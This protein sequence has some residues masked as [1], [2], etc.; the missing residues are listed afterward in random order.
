MTKHE[1]NQPVNPMDTHPKINDSD[2][3]LLQDE[4]NKSIASVAGPQSTG[5]HDLNGDGIPDA[6]L[7]WWNDKKVLFI[8]DDGTLPW[9][10]KEE[11]RDWNQ[12]F[13]EAFNVD[14]KPP[15]V[16]NETRRGWGS[17]TIL[18]DRDDCG[19]FGNST[20]WC[21]RCFDIN[22]DGDPEAEYY[23][24]FPGHEKLPYSNKVHINLNGERDMSILDFNNFYFGPEQ[25]YYKGFKYYTNVHG[26]GFFLN[27][28]SSNP[29]KAWENP[30]AW[31]DFDFDGRTN[32][33]MRVADNNRS[34]N[35]C[36]SGKIHEFELAYEL[37]GNTSEEQYHS[38]DMQLTF[39]D[40]RTSE[41]DYTGY[42]DRFPF[43]AP[44]PGTR[45]LSGQMASTR[46]ETARAYL[47]YLDGIKRCFEYGRWAGVFLLFDEDDDDC[48]WEEMFSNHE[49]EA[50]LDNCVWVQYSDR[51]G[52]RTEKDTDF[53]GGGKLYIGR[54]DGRIHLYHAEYA[55]WEIDYLA[56][57]KGSVDRKGREEEGPEPPEG[58]R[59]PQVRYY[60]TT[61]NG[62][63][64]QIVYSSVE[65]KN[66]KNTRQVIKT[67][68]LGDYADETMPSPDVTELH[69]PSE[70][71]LSVPDTGWSIEN[72]DGNPL[73]EKDFGKSPVKASFDD[74]FALYGKVCD[75]MWEGAWT[76]YETAKKHGLNRSESMDADLKL[77]YTR[78]ELAAM[79]E[80]AVPAGYSRHLSGKDRRQ[81]YHNGY[82]LREKVFEDILLY[83]G[84]DRFTLEKYYYRGE[85]DQLCRWIDEQMPDRSY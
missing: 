10:P 20:D 70:A 13:N 56:L 34:E 64:D 43:L 69:D 68:S 85:Y 5:Y 28:Y 21:Y 62:F 63:I 29:V 65:Y 17:Y 31:Y 23:H 83:S 73:T 46:F 84:L 11:N 74:L 49:G 45:E 77:T 30:I 18:V 3:S 39:L 79:K 48:R 44:A 55:F 58:L 71:P 75:A 1:K 16:W 52:D 66:E 32:M 7:F 80:L 4:G 54:F 19:G 26:N 9:G 42:L 57:Y 22:G 81:K 33:V 25:G 51:I 50:D 6:L 35:N 60:D 82:W 47:P 37:N 67:I 76:L 41:L 59:Y 78:E 24:L 12:Y 38:L 53:G 15:V 27:S 40:Y 36:Y 2:Q 8:S 14:A 61:G 72:W